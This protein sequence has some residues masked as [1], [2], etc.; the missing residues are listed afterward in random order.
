MMYLDRTSQD[1]THRH[2][3]VEDIPVLRAIER[4]VTFFTPP[5]VTQVS[6]FLAAAFCTTRGVCDG[7]T[8]D[9]HYRST[10]REEICFVRHA[11]L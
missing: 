6:D 10:D 3:S 1:L 7:F 4:L 11:E 8:L 9:V 5:T 2:T